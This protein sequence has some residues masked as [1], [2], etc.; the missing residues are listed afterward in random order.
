[1]IQFGSHYLDTLLAPGISEFNEVEIPELRDF[2]QSDHWLANLFLNSLFGPRYT[3]EWKQAAITFLFRTQTALRAYRSARK[4]TLACVDAFKPGQPASSL[5]FQAVADWEVVILNI[6]IVIDL[7]TR[8]MVPKQETDDARRIRVT[9]NRIKHY[10]E[11]IEEGKNSP[12]LTLPMWLTKTGVRTREA[13]VSYAELAENVVGLG[14]A[15]DLL[16][17]PSSLP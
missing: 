13:D 12:D 15:A 17:N 4:N 7:F 16:Q 3:D 2:P 5:Y 6:Q 11:D 8:V 10:A 14:D 9:G 1:M